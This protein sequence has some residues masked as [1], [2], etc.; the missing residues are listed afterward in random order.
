LEGTLTIAGQAA[1][2]KKLV[3]QLEAGLWGVDDSLTA[4]TD[5]RGYFRM[6]RVPPGQHTLFRSVPT[7]FFGRMNSHATSVQVFPGRTSTVNFLSPGA[8]VSG[9]AVLPPEVSGMTNLVRSGMLQT[10]GPTPSGEF[11]SAEALEA[12]MASP[13]VQNFYR[14]RKDYV[15][16]IAPDG[17]FLIDGVLPGNYRLILTATIRSMK[18]ELSDETVAT[19]IVEVEVPE[20]ADAGTPIAVGPVAMSRAP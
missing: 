7:G 20:A 19:G 5:A 8:L 6:E 14:I 2:G 11:A 15:V 9:V 4:V 16:E 17:R 12:W 1:A 10:K 13:E 18:Q 3:L